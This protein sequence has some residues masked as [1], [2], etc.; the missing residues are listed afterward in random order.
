MIKRRWAGKG[1]QLKR[2]SWGPLLMELLTAVLLFSVVGAVAMV[3]FVRADSLNRRSEQLSWS[4]DQAANIGEILRSSD[5]LAE[6]KTTMVQEFPEAEAENSTVRPDGA[7][8]NTETR[9]EEELTLRLYFD[10]SL[11]QVSGEEQA[12]LLILVRADCREGMLTARVF[13][14]NTG[15]QTELY[16]QECEHYTGT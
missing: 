8:E 2:R 12:D 11:Q 6:F 9:P 7:S 1:R 3:F 5:S 4:A 15:Q 14:Q 13:V 16:S 10:T